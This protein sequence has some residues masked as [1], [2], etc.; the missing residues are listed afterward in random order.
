MQRII[1]LWWI[2]CICIAHVSAQKRVIDSSV[3]GKWESIQGGDLSPDGKYFYC[4]IQ[5]P[6]KG[7][8][9]IIKA[10]DRLWERSFWNISQGAILRDNR[11]FVFQ[12]KDSLYL[13]RLGTNEI[14]YIARIQAFQV[15]RGKG[16]EWLT[17][18]SPTERGKSRLVLRPTDG[19]REWEIDNARIFQS[20]DACDALITQKE[21]SSQSNSSFI[22]EW[23]D[24][25][26]GKHKTFWKGRQILDMTFDHSGKQIAFITAENVGEVQSYRLWYYRN[27]MVESKQLSIEGN[28]DS[29]M[30][31]SNTMLEFNFN[32]DKLF[33]ELKGRLAE[34]M[35]T[36]GI[37]VDVWSYRDRTI[38]EEAL[39]KA[40]RPSLYKS[41]MDLQT[42]KTLQLEKE[43]LQLVRSNYGTREF[44][45]LRRGS[46]RDCWWR[47][48]GAPTYYLAPLKG[49][50]PVLLKGKIP[51]GNR[52]IWIQNVAISP[53]ER[54]V[55]YYNPVDG[56]YYSYEIGT[57]HIKDI[58][59]GMGVSLTR[60]KPS[61]SYGSLITTGA[62]D[63][64]AWTENDRAILLYDNWDIWLVDPLGIE[65]AINLTGGYGRANHIKYQLLM[66]TNGKTIE[67]IRSNADLL[68]SADDTATMYSGFYRLRLDRPGQPELLT[69]GP[70]KYQCQMRASD[71]GQY[72]V[73][74]EN[75]EEAPNYY[76]SHDLKKFTPVTQVAPQEEYNW[77]HV[78]LVTW[79]MPDGWLC[80]GM[81]FKPE[82][83]DE[84]RKYP[85]IVHYYEEESH[86]LYKYNEPELSGDGMNIPYFVSRGYVVFVPDML[87]LE[88]AMGKRALETVVSGVRFLS[89]ERWID[90]AHMGIQG[91]SFGGYE[92]N[93]IV[94]HTN[95]FAAAAEGFGVSDMISDY[96]SLVYK[97]ETNHF[98][99]DHG[100]YCTWASPWERPEAYLDGSP[101]LRADKV[102]T[103]ILIIHNKKD[104]AVPWLQGVEFFIALRR[105]DKKV[106]M[107][108]YDEGSHGVSGKEALDFTVRLEQFF[109]HY[110]KGAPPPLW[111]TEG[112]PASR[113][114]LD[115]GLQLDRSGRQ[116]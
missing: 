29:C 110:L 33:F 115:D 73:S 19:G 111:M 44:V 75:A 47:E 74:R 7:D 48:P 80:H 71:A 17:Y 13:V 21:D 66:Q 39:A 50:Q 112:I 102:T 58:T 43:D 18:I 91:A 98:I 106:W 16:S 103:P 34:K 11:S 57:G 49:G 61:G 5:Y 54:F 15:L 52:A 81:L 35:P 22:Y 30:T 10:T 114:G 2:S 90:T 96:C 40:R 64:A 79:P 26:T 104:P 94:T 51:F 42:G 99:F 68:L 108:Q 38:Q 84:L 92:T 101:I 100:V 72:L 78:E 69:M 62:A 85:L 6:G 46:A 65:K 97:G 32:D 4:R 107:V 23:R 87:P 109:D 95:L 76:I 70:Y 59:K 113:K 105:N 37:K 14:N 60:W 28:I 20:N 83:F 31:L 63:I 45:L 56:D 36:T 89:K 8:L 116:P 9:A 82:N 25:S 12:R 41:C 67:S 53:E 55:T 93:Y 88:G 86:N 1:V 77:L 3:F 24:L 27:D